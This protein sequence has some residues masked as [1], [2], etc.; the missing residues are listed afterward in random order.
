MSCL[1]SIQISREQQYAGCRLERG[2][3][4]KQQNTAT[5]DVE[6]KKQVIESGM[7]R[8]EHYGVE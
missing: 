2:S 7:V 5:A 4:V 6:W 3:V 1:G 8:A